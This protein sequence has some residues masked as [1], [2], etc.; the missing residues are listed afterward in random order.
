MTLQINIEVPEAQLILGA[1]SK[2]PLEVSLDIWHKVKSQAE[3]QLQAQQAQQEPA[4]EPGL[5]DPQA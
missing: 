2:L 5:N 1:L 4:P 3:A